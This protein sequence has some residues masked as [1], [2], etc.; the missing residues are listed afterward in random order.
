M[1]DLFTSNGLPLKVHIPS[2]PPEKL[3]VIVSVHG[4][5]RNYEEHVELIKDKCSS[6]FAIVAPY[7]DET[8]YG[9]Y[10]KLGVGY[11]EARADLSLDA[12]LDA[13][14][15]ATG[16]ETRKFHL[17][18]FSGGAQFAH[19]YTLANPNRIRSLHLAAAGY[20]TFLND[21]VAW[22]RGLRNCPL[23]RI[24]NA[25]RNFFLRLPIDVYVGERDDVRDTTLRQGPRID[26]QQ[27][28]NR[29]ER[30]V[31]WTKHVRE[32]QRRSHL[33]FAE[34]TILPQVGHDFRQACTTGK[35]VEILL[36][37]CLQDRPKR[38]ES[39]RRRRREVCLDDVT[40]LTQ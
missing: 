8:R 12:A 38:A 2:G 34:L 4:I 27:G 28:E 24:V 33:S 29:L 21:S 26:P 5:S 25:N 16:L 11:R 6:N 23:Q 7:F 36:E 14:R 13:L 31:R 9:H 3:E 22:P 35:L 32:L 17:L 1:S 37:K 18:G 40:L 20:Y 10:Q 39:H 30:A 15:K 19:R